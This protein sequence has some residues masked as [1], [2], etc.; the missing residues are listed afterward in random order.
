MNSTNRG[1]SRKGPF[2]GLMRAFSRWIGWKST[3]GK[4]H[5][6]PEKHYMRGPGPKAK[7]SGGGNKTPGSA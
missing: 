4:D 2:K 3:L 1:K 7:R 6:R 5:Y